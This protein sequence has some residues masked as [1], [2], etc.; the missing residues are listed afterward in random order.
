MPNPSFLKRKNVISGVWG[1]VPICGAAINSFQFFMKKKNCFSS[2]S[3]QTNPRNAAARS[4]QFCASGHGMSKQILGKHYLFSHASRLKTLP[5]NEASGVA[6]LAHPV[7]GVQNRYWVNT[8]RSVYEGWDSS[9]FL[10]KYCRIGAA[11]H[12]RIVEICMTILKKDARR[13]LEKSE[14]LIR[15]N[16]EN[17]E[18]RKLKNNKFSFSFDYISQKGLH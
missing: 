16:S 11:D 10:R 7:P 9:D 14:N 15:E 18:H 2:E 4:G 8:T 17:V 12:F 6:C 5:R 3:E 13:C 1:H